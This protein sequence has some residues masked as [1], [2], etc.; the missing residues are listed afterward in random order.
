MKSVSS[1]GRL[2]GHLRSALR[3][4]LTG[5]ALILAGC[6]GDDASQAPSPSATQ[7][8]LNSAVLAISIS[9]TEADRFQTVIGTTGERYYAARF[10]TTNGDRRMA[11]ARLSPTGSLDTSF[12]HGGIATVNVAVG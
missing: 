2:Y 5:S 11:L 9:T 1:V 8:T 4:V 3:V 10:D 6:S 12:G 7:S